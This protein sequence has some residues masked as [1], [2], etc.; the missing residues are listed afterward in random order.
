MPGPGRAGGGHPET[1][2]HDAR[3]KR[4]LHGQPDNDTLT[5]LADRVAE[6]AA[7]EA[8]ALVHTAAGLAGKGQAGVL[9]AIERAAQRSAAG[10]GLAAMTGVI[11]WASQHATGQAQ[12]PHSDAHQVRLVAQRSKTVRTLLGTLEISRGY[13]HCRT[14]QQAGTP[15][16][17]APLDDRLGVAGTSLSPGLSR[18]A[19]LAGAEM[20]YA[21]GFELITTVTGPDLASVSTLA[22]TTRHHG[23]RARMLI[24]TEHTA[25]LTT[26]RPVPAAWANL[27]DLCY[28]VLDG[29]GAPMLPRETQGRTGKDGARASTREVKIGCF[30]TQTGLDPATSEPIQNPDSVSYISTFHAADS[31]S[32]QVKAEYLRRGFDQIRQPIMLG[33][34]AKWIWTIA[35][36]QAPHATQIVDYYHA[37]EHLATL[38]KLVH[39]L[40]EDPTNWEQHLI[41]ALDLGNTNTIADTITALDLPTNAP[42]LIAD[43]TRETR[44]FTNNHQ[45]Q[46]RRHALDHHRPRPHPRPPHPPPIPTRPHPVA[47]HHPHTTNLTH[48]HSCRWLRWMSPP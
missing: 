38:T 9:E 20:P 28:L 45:S 16:G 32:R 47:Q 21:K 29:T 3:G 1:P 46:T 23:T 40:L 44:Y 41:D 24:D 17:F 42:S 19:A 26:P 25:A 37:R 2:R 33:D 48:T 15:G 39:S 35:D 27:P 12:C 7:A 10:I 36:Q 4:G 8:R 6:I 31:F 18:A 14:C 5:A 11:N 43:T 22:R 13:Y 30:F 34:G